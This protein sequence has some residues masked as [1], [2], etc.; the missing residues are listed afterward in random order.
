[1]ASQPTAT[2]LLALKIPRNVLDKL[3]SSDEIKLTL[4]GKEKGIGGSMVIAGMRF[5]VRYRAERG[6]TSLVFQGK[7]PTIA[8][9][10]SA[11]AHWEPHGKVTGRLTLLPPKGSQLAERRSMA[12]PTELTT[13]PL[14][15]TQTA[16]S[17]M[18]EKAVAE[19]T[20]Q[21]QQQ[22]QL[23]QQQQRAKERAAAKQAPLKRPGVAAQ[24]QKHL[25]QTRDR[26]LHYL[27]F[28]PC[29]EEKAIGKLKGSR[30]EVLDILKSIATADGTLW[31]LRPERFC[32]VRIMEWDKYKDGL[33]L[34]VAANCLAAF[35][36][37]G[38]PAD[39][40]DRLRVIDVQKKLKAII[41]NQR[42]QQGAEKS[43][44]SAAPAAAITGPPVT[45]AVASATSALPNTSVI[46]S[47]TVPSISL[48]KEASA[49]K[50]KPTRSVIAPTLAKTLGMKGAK[51]TKRKL[52][53]TTDALTSLSRSTANASTGTGT[54]VSAGAGANTGANTGTAPTR[55]SVTPDTSH[56]TKL[57]SKRT[58]LKNEDGE[59]N[60]GEIREEGETS[61]PEYGKAAEL[62]APSKPGLQASRGH[63]H[64]ASFQGD[65]QRNG[66]SSQSRLPVDR[67]RF[68]RLRAESDVH[69]ASDTEADYS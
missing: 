25:K 46:R 57:A 35:D 15:S 19:Q 9:G 27:A 26:L 63:S 67:K 29:E 47:P 68:R 64:S 49:A 45:V 37:L 1:M 50:K 39:D 13:A 69:P 59:L 48:P 24:N 31:T 58:V 51:P 22:Q 7:P 11:S 56:D 60:D 20:Q 54:G 43:G 66:P 4:G 10:D 6:G 17:S 23:H 28:Q 36:K 5:D 12:R 53:G 62:L 34:Q 16:F 41:A 61:G 2:P 33:R 44:V 42:A 8:G 52:T 65:R 18:V 55:P 21:Q 40:P 38:L 30:Q 14:D 3:R 32:E